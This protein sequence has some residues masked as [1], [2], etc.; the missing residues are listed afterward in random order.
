MSIM[1]FGKG[2]HS[3]WNFSNFD[4]KERRQVKVLSYRTWE[5][6]V[7]LRQQRQEQKKKK[8]KKKT[9]KNYKKLL[10]DIR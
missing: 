1:N 9:I 6:Y 10:Y 5:K 2:K 8:K 7:D 4:Q 3:Q